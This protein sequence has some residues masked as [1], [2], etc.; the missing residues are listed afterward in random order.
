MTRVNWSVSQ[1]TAG[2]LRRRPNFAAHL[3]VLLRYLL[4]SGPKEGS[5]PNYTVCLR[6]TG[7]AETA[8]V[9]PERIQ[10]LIVHE[11]LHSFGEHER[12]LFPRERYF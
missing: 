11:I 6:V 7:A 8:S 12:S 3:V 9:V 5:R 10:C 4:P 2:I 1:R